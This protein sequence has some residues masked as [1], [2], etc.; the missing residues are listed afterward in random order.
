[1]SGLGAV[2]AQERRYNAGTQW[3][4]EE[5]RSDPLGHLDWQQ[6][7]S[8]VNGPQL[9]QRSQ[10]TLQTGVLTSGAAAFPQNPT[11]NMVWPD[12]V[13]AATKPSGGVVRTGEVQ[14]NF[15]SGT[16][17]FMARRART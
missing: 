6:R 9:E 2:V 13:T 12:E 8:A 16:Y 3:Q 15:N 11:T 1:M 4:I 14:R 7:K 10:F 5:Y 17:S